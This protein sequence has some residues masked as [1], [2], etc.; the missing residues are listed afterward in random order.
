MSDQQTIAEADIPLV[1]MGDDGGRR[2]E[3]QRNERL[4]A[5]AVSQRWPVKP[6][7]REMLVKGQVMIALDPSQPP[8][9]RT[10]AFSA[11]VNADRVNLEIEGVVGA[12]VNVN[13]QVNQSVATAREALEH[14]PD[15]LSY[16]E[17]KQL[18]GHRDTAAVGENGVERPVSDAEPS[19][20]DEPGRNGHA[21]RN[22]W[23]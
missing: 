1:L 9:D 17:S 12:G 6:E 20:A 5:R 19:A 13:V 4:A 15:Y 7:W 8:R 3:Q 21:S 18:G 10:R 2:I 16:I 14:E 11:V 22:G 23:H